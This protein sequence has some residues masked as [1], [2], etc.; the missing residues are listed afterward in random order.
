MTAVD[1][2]ALQVTSLA[3]ATEYDFLFDRV[4]RQLV[5]GYNVSERRCDASHYDL[6]AS[7]ARL[8]N[9]VAIAQG[10]L[11]QESWF[12]LGRLLTSADGRSVLLAWSGSMFEYLMPLLVMPTYE[13][14]LLDQTY[15]AAVERQI[16]YGRQRG[17]PWGM[18]ESGYNTVDAHLNYQYRAFRR[19]RTGPETRAGRR[20]RGGAV[21]IRARLDGRTPRG[22]LE[23][24][25]LVRRRLGR[26]LRVVRGNRLH[27]RAAAAG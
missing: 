27:T 23:L 20:P 7:E 12:A 2:L 15:E 26:A 11:P 1:A 9:F 24:A 10:K 17:V 6:L 8:C 5:I 14:T 22:M 4:R 19:S 18:S 3:G 21:C 25:T 13:N 16:A